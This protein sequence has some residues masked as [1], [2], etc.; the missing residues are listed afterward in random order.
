M[1]LSKSV[2]LVTPT[3]GFIKCVSLK[4]AKEKFIGYIKWKKDESGQDPCL[5]YYGDAD[6]FLLNNLAIVR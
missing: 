6:A 4:D 2:K 3:G 1:I 5:V